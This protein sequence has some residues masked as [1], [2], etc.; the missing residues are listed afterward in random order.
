[1]SALEG[2]DVDVFLL[3]G[4][5]RFAKPSSIVRVKGHKMEVIREGVLQ[6]RILT[7]LAALQI[8]FVCTGNTCRSPM[9]EAVAKKL[10]AEKI[11]C[12]IPE[13]P[14]HNVRVLS[15]GTSGGLGEASEQSVRVMAERGLDISKH[16]SRPVSEEMLSQSDLILTMT[17]A[18]LDAIRHLAPDAGERAQRLLPDRD[19]PDPIG[20]SDAEYEAC[21]AAIETG[22]A[23]RLKEVEI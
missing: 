22:V 4:E 8:L 1:V 23:Q 13:L 14:S 17:T 19:V 15:A 2:V 7:R 20:G 10:L 6:E 3:G 9:A 21:A 16:T 12:P 11:G 18:Q 5:T